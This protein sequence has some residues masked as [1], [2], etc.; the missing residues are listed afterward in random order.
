MPAWG[1][2]LPCQI[3]GPAS[4]IYR[5]QLH[6]TVCACLTSKHRRHAS[7]AGK[8]EGPAILEEERKHLLQGQHSLLCAPGSFNAGSRTLETGHIQKECRPRPQILYRTQDLQPLFS[9]LPS[10]GCPPGV[11]EEPLQQDGSKAQYTCPA[12]F[13]GIQ[14]ETN[15]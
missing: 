5:A 13:H 1:Y 10:A 8:R 6:E 4:R 15:G 12:T 9:G 7:P 2:E 14:E 11:G 3:L